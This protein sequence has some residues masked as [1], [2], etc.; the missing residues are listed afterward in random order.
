MYRDRNRREAGRRAFYDRLRGRY[1]TTSTICRCLTPSIN[2]ISYR[3]VLVRDRALVARPPPI[4]PFYRKLLRGIYSWL[5]VSLHPTII[6]DASYA[7][8]ASFPL[9]R[10]RRERSVR[11]S[12]SFIP[13]PLPIK[14]LSRNTRIQSFGRRR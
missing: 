11:L 7:T 3:H 12:R 13:H 4:R 8:I 6:T 1:E 9:V 14:S 2:L 10:T 5:L